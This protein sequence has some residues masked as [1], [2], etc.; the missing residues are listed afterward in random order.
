MTGG[1]F[2]IAELV[3]V[4]V[5]GIAAMI[6]TLLREAGTVVI[7][8]IFI[9]M[10]WMLMGTAF[11]IRPIWLAVNRKNYGEAVSAV[12]E[13]SYREKYAPKHEWRIT[14]LKYKRKEFTITNVMFFRP[15]PGKTCE[16]AFHKRDKERIILPSAALVNSIVFAAAGIIWETAFAV[17]IANN[18]KQLI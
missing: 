8:K 4:F 2:K 12:V 9:F 10:A 7:P 15:I 14:R 1:G 16:I 6:L 18:F 17:Y 5:S 13:T 3:I 11:F